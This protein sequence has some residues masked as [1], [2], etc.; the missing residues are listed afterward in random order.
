M[1]YFT[2]LH[3]SLGFFLVVRRALGVLAFLKNGKAFS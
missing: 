1:S 2:A 3:C